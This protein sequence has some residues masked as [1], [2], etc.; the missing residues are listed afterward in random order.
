MPIQSPK[1]RAIYNAVRRIPKGRVAT[2]GQIAAL[3]KLPGHA[4]LVGY[5]LSALEENHNVPWHRVINAKGQI[6]T[7]YDPQLEQD[8]LHLL[9]AENITLNAKGIIDLNKYRWRPRTKTQP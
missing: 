9:Q 1:Y 5:A 6:S 7:R 3:A 8:Q 4:R 2:Y